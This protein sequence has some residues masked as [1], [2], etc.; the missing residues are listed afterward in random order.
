MTST[1]GVT[2]ICD[3]VERDDPLRW[4]TSM[5]APSQHAADDIEEFLAEAVHVAGQDIDL[6]QIQFIK[7]S[8]IAGMATHLRLRK[9][10]AVV[11]AFNK[12]AFLLTK[13]KIIQNGT[14]NKMNIRMIPIGFHSKACKKSPLMIDKTDLVDPQEGQ[15]IDVRCLKIH[16]PGSIAWDAWRNKVIASQVYPAAQAVDNMT[17]NLFLVM[18]VNK[19]V[20]GWSAYFFP[21]WHP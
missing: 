20:D 8:R 19:V 17:Y 2:L 3:K 10:S 1:N 4:P 7:T 14:L 21:W 5:S 9:S 15:G 16:N 11:Y 12:V 6:T 13:S 18:S